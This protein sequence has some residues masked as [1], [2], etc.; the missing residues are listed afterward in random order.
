MFI[1]KNKAVTDLIKRVLSGASIQAQ[2]RHLPAPS[3]YQIRGNVSARGIDSTLN[4]TQLSQ[5]ANESFMLKNTWQ[6]RQKNQWK[7]LG[8]RSCR[9]M[10]RLYWSRRI[11]TLFRNSNRCGGEMSPALLKQ[12]WKKN[13]ASDSRV[14][15]KPQILKEDDLG[16]FTVQYPYGWSTTSR[17]GAVTLQNETTG[18]MLACINSC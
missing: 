13:G 2:S 15:A 12:K 5:H 18:D 3:D 16:H 1:A 9:L 10:A 8:I 17:K 7:I 14:K 4:P 6:N 11:V